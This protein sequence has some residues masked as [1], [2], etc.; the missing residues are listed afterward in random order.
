[1]T[2]T[3]SGP[4]GTLVQYQASGSING[5]NGTI[6]LTLD[7]PTGTL[8]SQLSQVV[9]V[10]VNAA[11]LAAGTYTGTITVTDTSGQA[12]SVTEQVK[13]TVGSDGITGTYSGTYHGT[14]TDTNFND[15]PAQGSVTLTISTVTSA[16]GGAITGTVQV[17]NFFGHTI[18]LPF[19]GTSAPGVWDPQVTQTPQFGIS[20]DMSQTNGARIQMVA[21]ITGSPGRYTLSGTINIADMYNQEGMNDQMLDQPF[22]IMQ[23]G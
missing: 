18:S 7:K 13:L 4:S 17:T 1:L 22:T 3:N 9:N 8:A 12:A 2:I 10:S 16:S 19:G 11:G 5:P 21:P 15:V 14:A 6:T 20:T 23:E